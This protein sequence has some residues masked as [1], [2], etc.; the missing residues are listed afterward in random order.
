[1]CTFRYVGSKIL[2]ARPFPAL[3][4][5]LKPVGKDKTAERNHLH[6]F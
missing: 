6:F 2:Y 5:V 3:L 1:M 4:F